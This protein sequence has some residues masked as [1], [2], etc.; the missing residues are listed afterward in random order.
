M[1]AL[2]EVLEQEV[3]DVPFE[4]AEECEEL[5]VEFE[6]LGEGARSVQIVKADALEATPPGRRPPRP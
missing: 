1:P 2:H 5:A 6:R 3:L 4:V